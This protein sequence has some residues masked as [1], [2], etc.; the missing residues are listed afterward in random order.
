MKTCCIILIALLL[1]PQWLASVYGH[2]L[3]REGKP[4]ANAQ[5]KYTNVGAVDYSQVGA[6][7]I[8]DGTG[9]IYK[10]KTDKKGEFSLLGVEYGVYQIEIT[11]AD[12]SHAY[13]GKKNIGDNTDL[14]SQ[15]VLNIDLS[16][17]EA[18][19][20]PAGAGTNLGAGKKGKD[21][22]A[23][24]RQENAN[25]VKI[26]RLI[27]QLHGAL[28]VQDWPNATELL[29][30]LIV[31]DANRWEFYQN[32]G[33]I[34]AN[35]T[36][37]EEAVQNFAKGVTVAEKMLA[38]AA[39]PAA[40]KII[41]SDLL[42]SEGDGYNRLGKLDQA[43]ELYEKASG[44][45]PAPATAHYHACNALNNHGQTEAAIETCR[46]AIA[47]DPAQWEFYQTLGSA[48]NTAEKHQDALEAY[49]QGVA[50]AS[51]MLAGQPDSSRA[52][53]GLGQMLNSEGNLLVQMKRYDDAA[54]IFGE[55]AK[56]SSYPAM[57]Y[58]NL[59][60]TYYNL[61]RSADAVAACDQAI[62]SDA[63][64]ADAYFI[65]ASVLFGQGKLDQGYYVTPSGTREAL[66]KYLEYAPFGDHANDVR[67]MIGKLDARVE[68]TVK[69]TKK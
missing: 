32:L 62:A 53:T 22:L 37:Y 47:E 65:K 10:T 58:F 67:A 42:L 68:I 56:V 39:D 36:H 63:T 5:I 41:I 31:L 13:S 16:T 15:N 55:A 54:G 44:L 7:K 14:N 57:P 20:V 26:N 24:I 43:I 19:L 2:I 33:T 23:L 34:Q 40:A 45:S 27:V 4:L 50:A 11:A 48:L 12:G 30:Q 8:K 17:A 9:R 3:D 64:M 38:N 52:K 35:Q 66:N 61:R 49:Q 21:Q 46:K 18:G 25:A 1:P 60:A 6:A 51:K 29:N 59:C 28:D 69:P